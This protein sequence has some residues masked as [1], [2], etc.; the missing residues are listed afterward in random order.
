MA[1]IFIGSS[2]VLKW[3]NLERLKRAFVLAQTRSSELKL[4]LA[5]YP[6]N[7]FLEKI[8]ASYAVILASLGDI[9][10]NLILEA[11]RAG[12]PFI[13][14]NENGLENRLQGLGLRVDPESEEDL[15]EKIIELCQPEVYEGEK[16]K[17]EG[18]HFRH[19]WS[20]IAREFLDLA[21]P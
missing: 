10:P 20:E 6:H 7:Q 4:D 19:D 15:A 8:K 14:T 11:I 21:K 13:L 12:K 17:L 9:S 16:A 18:F 5:L 2:R 1:K 3:K